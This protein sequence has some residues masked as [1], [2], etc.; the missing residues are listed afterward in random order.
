MQVE[1][2]LEGVRGIVDTA[3]MEPVLVAHIHLVLQ[4]L[5][6]FMEI[7]LLFNHQ[8]QKHT[9]LSNINI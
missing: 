5:V 3:G 2:L 7:L 6:Q 1:H 4:T 9:S 8:Q